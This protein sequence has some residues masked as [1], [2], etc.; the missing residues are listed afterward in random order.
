[1]PAPYVGGMERLVLH[2]DYCRRTLIIHGLLGAVAIGVT[3][4]VLN[5]TGFGTQL[6]LT[7]VSAL[8]VVLLASG[9]ASWIELRARARLLRDL[10]DTGVRLP[11]TLVDIEWSDDPES[12][13]GSGLWPYSYQGR[14]YEIR[15]LESIFV[16]VPP[17]ATALV[18]PSRPERA[19]LL[20]ANGITRGGYPLSEGSLLRRIALGL[21]LA[22]TWGWWI[23]AMGLVLVRR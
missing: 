8:A 14:R 2:D 20:M 17:D 4:F 22:A 16:K 18:D 23:V 6:V 19:V 10:M 21:L 9:L 11:V 15:T 7:A 3:G 1:M 12:S 13:Y 5:A